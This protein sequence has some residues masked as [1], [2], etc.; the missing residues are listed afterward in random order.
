MSIP[1]RPIDAGFLS[2][3]EYE[4]RRRET[5]RVQLASLRVS[6]RYQKYLGQK[7]LAWCFRLALQLVALMILVVAL[8]GVKDRFLGDDSNS[9]VTI[10]EDEGEVVRTYGPL[11]M[12]RPF[13]PKHGPS[14]QEPGLD[15]T[16][17][18]RPGEILN[19]LG[20]SNRTNV[21]ERLVVEKY[22]FDVGVTWCVYKCLQFLRRKIF[23]F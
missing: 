22:F 16:L 5:T 20:E 2:V 13:L 12:Y 4:H 1:F 23:G 8:G 17:D 10:P 14:S 7:K 9:T 21:M 11:P 19:G 3:E 15:A 18:E 6:G